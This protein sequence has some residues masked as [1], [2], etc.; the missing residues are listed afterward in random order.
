MCWYV[1][2]SELRPKLPFDPDFIDY[3]LCSHILYSAAVI[4]P[5][6]YDVVFLQNNVKVIWNNFFSFLLI[7]NNEF[8]NQRAT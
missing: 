3:N 4:D 5:E 6:K 8:I 2:W 7:S 1:N